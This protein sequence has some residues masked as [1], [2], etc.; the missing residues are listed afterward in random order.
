M[1]DKNITF[2]FGGSEENQETTGVWFNFSP[3][4]EFIPLQ[5]FSEFPNVNGIIISN[6]NSSILKKGFFTREFR[7]IQYLD[8]AVNK[9][10]HIEEV[11]FINLIE[12]KWISLYSNQIQSIKT[13]MFSNNINL[14]N[15]NFYDNKIKM[16]NPTFFENLHKLLEVDLSGNICVDSRFKKSDSSLSTMNK[17]LQNC[18]DNC[19]NDDAC[20]SN[21][22]EETTD[23]KC[24]CARN[25]NMLIMKID[26]TNVLLTKIVD[27][28]KKNKI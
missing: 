18:F 23:E 28:L 3:T 1:S 11:A 13:N 19:L 17:K 26:Q 25:L 4:I 10:Q 8:L 12:L 22:D 14:E 2:L 5:I 15:I 20:L 24:G 7:S 16:I 27:F 6:S 9:I 21:V